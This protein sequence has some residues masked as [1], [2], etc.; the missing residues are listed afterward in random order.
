MLMMMTMMIRV[1]K[2]VTI[3]LGIPH[4]P[5]PN[6]PSRPSP[7]VVSVYVRTRTGP[8]QAPRNYWLFIQIM[9]K[10]PPPSF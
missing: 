7:P 6:L 2:V 4:P 9:T 1:I 5:P 8:V 3:R 10:P